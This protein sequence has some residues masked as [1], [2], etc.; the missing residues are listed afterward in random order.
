MS[1]VYRTSDNRQFKCIC[2]YVGGQ[3]PN[4]AVLPLHGIIAG[5]SGLMGSARLQRVWGAQTPILT[6]PAMSVKNAPFSLPR[7]PVPRPCTTRLAARRGDRKKTGP[8]ISA[9]PRRLVGKAT[10][11]RHAGWASEAS[12]IGLRGAVED[13]GRSSAHRSATRIL[14]LYGLPM[15]S[16][17]VFWRSNA[18]IR[19]VDP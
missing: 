10:A 17:G 1:P 15:A 4:T 16:G 8:A 6:K 14:G 7:R 2:H 11:G 13:L 3:R 19:P 9:T 12:P 5:P 18:L